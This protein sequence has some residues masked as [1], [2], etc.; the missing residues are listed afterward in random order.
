M[1]D[2]SVISLASFNEQTSPCHVNSNLMSSNDSNSGSSASPSEEQVKVNDRTTLIEKAQSFLLSPTIRY[3]DED[4]KRRFLQEKGLTPD[5][6]ERL[7]RELP[8]QPP[9]IPPRTYPPPPPS[10]L[11]ILLASLLRVFTWTIGISGVIFMGYYKFLLPRMTRSLGARHKLKL[12]QIELMSRLHGRIEEMRKTR[13]ETYYALPPTESEEL[14]VEIKSFSELPMSTDGESIHPLILI[15]RCAFLEQPKRRLT[16]DELYYQLI[17]QFPGF[18]KRNEHEFKRHIKHEI[19]KSR[20]FDKD[21][22]SGIEYWSLRVHTDSHMSTARSL[23]ILRDT[24]SRS[25]RGRNVYQHTFKSLTDLTA[26]L[27]R[28]TFALYGSNAGFRLPGGH[29]LGPAEE[30]V[31]RDI[32]AL[33]GL[34]LNRR[35]FAPTT[36]RPSLPPVVATSTP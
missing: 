8:R 16:I 31:R 22:E 36:Y 9:P 34:V 4:A 25:F 19:L 5:E 20:L 21:A 24:V 32:R 23:E 6:I 30:E 15:I 2:R 14:P 35:S 27:S 10:N 1:K 7:I 3:E 17:T 28:E 26:F 29:L 18:S 33:K 13:E 11:P 12:H